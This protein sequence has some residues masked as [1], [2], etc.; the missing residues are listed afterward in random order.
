MCLHRASIHQQRIPH[1]LIVNK[2]KIFTS[3]SLLQ[4][5][6]TLPLGVTKELRQMLHIKQLDGFASMTVPR[7]A[8]Q[9]V[10]VSRHGTI[11]QYRRSLS[12]FVCLC[13]NRCSSVLPS[14]SSTSETQIDGIK[15]SLVLLEA[16]FPG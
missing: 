8:S 5:T 16:L 3:D 13:G 10:L 4:R 15:V 12:I 6:I 14:H 2:D 1:L 9:T 11:E 7:K